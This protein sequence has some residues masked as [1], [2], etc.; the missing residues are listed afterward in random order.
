MKNQRANS[1]KMTYEQQADLVAYGHFF[2]ILTV[3]VSLPLIFLISWWYKIAL[4]LTLSTFISWIPLRGHCWITKLE[5]KFR[6]KHNPSSVYN[7]GFIEH[8][9][10]KTFNIHWPPIIFIILLDS[11]IFTLFF[12]AVRQALK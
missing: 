3:L 6:R 11:Y 4:I 5:N 12:L 8:H 9:L 7:D 2:F 10:T 1:K